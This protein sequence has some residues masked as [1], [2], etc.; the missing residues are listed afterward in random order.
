MA[1]A[2][3]GRDLLRPV[4][5]VAIFLPAEAALGGVRLREWRLPV[6]AGVRVTV[7]RRSMVWYGEVGVVAALLNER[8]PDLLESTP[9]TALE[10]GGRVSLGLRWPSGA[11]LAP[12]LALSVE[13]VPWPPSVAALPTGILGRTSHVW[14]GACFGLSW[15]APWG[16][17]SGTPGSGP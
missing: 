13:I 9:S 4:L 14:P 8:A 12:F 5:G 6:D 2:V 17:E 7:V 15:G 10:V 11:A 16:T 1:R 3:L